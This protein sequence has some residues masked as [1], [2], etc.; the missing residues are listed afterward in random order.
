MRYIGSKQALLENL[1]SEIGKKVKREGKFCDLFSGSASV[2]RHFKRNGFQI[3]SNDIMHFSYYLQAATI[4]LNER[5]KFEGLGF[6][7]IEKLNSINVGKFGFTGEKF[8]LQN[9]APSDEVQTGYFTRKNAEKIDAT[10]QQIQQWFDS[11]KISWLEFS[12][13]V[14]ALIEAVPFISNTTGTYGAYLKTWDKRALKDLKIE[15]LEIFNNDLTNRSY[16][17]DGNDLIKS[18]EGEILYIDP[19]Y[20]NRQ[21][22]SNYHVLE[23]IAR[24][25]YPKV[26]GI[27]SMRDNKDVRS[28]FCVKS[29][30]QQTLED[31]I[32]N[33]NFDF[34]FLSYNTEGILSVEQIEEMFSKHCVSGSFDLV[35]I[36]YR[37]YKRVKEGRS[38]QLYELLFSG[39]KK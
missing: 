1:S 35:K 22:G 34:V 5:P 30:A 14:A 19:P 10:R 16:C 39:K 32:S 7:P 26:K 38:Q 4:E 37:R 2:A 9:Y 36:P 3:I 24:Y 20:N 29:Q 28:S 6:N 18:I 12:Y 31:L 15:N 27:T 13:L 33:A 21:Y 11:K 25:D 8:V 23:T 17:R